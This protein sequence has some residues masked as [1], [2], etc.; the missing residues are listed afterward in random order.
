MTPSPRVARTLLLSLSL[1]L[2]T[3]VGTGFRA[4]PPAASPVAS[5]ATS[6]AASPTASPADAAATGSVEGRVVDRAG[7]PVAG[8]TVRI[9]CAEPFA[10]S[11]TDE[12]GWFRAG[13]LAPGRTC[14][15]ATRAGFA[16]ARLDDLVLAD[17][18]VRVVTLQAERGVAL[19]GTLKTG[20]SPA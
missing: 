15:E 7:L 20:G 2:A 1:S 10:T 12:R 4:G 9:G 13:G 6:S 5:P 8:A 17:R 16:P 19:R 3:T 18:A 14:L 11:T